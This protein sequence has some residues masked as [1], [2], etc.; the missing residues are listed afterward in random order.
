MKHIVLTKKVI[1]LMSKDNSLLLE[2]FN[3][4]TYT[5]ESNDAGYYVDFKVSNSANQLSTSKLSSIIGKN[6]DGK[7][8]VGFVVFVKNGYI[9]CFEGYTFG[10]EKWPSSDEEISIEIAK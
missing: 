8:I 2:Q 5:E 7:I 3:A 1:E 9:D 4:A 10:D 6:K